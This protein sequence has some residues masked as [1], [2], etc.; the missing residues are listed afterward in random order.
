V[1]GAALNPDA[2]NGN[3]RFFPRPEAASMRRITKKPPSYRLHKPSNRAV[4]TLDGRD[5]YLGP[6]GSEESRAEYDRVVAEWLVHRCRAQGSPSSSSNPGMTVNELLVLYWRFAEEHYRRDGRP[7]RHLG[8]IRD[9]LRPVRALY[10]RTEA[11]EFGAAAFKAVR[12][13]MIDSGLARRTIAGRTGKVRQM[14]RWAVENEL[15]PPAVYQALVAVSGLKKGRGGVRETAP[16][17]PVPADR[18]EAVLPYLTDQVRGLV[19]L[20]LLA[21][22]RPGETVAMRADEIDCSGDVWVYRPTRHKTEGSDRARTILIGPRAQEVVRPFLEAAADDGY[23]FHPASAVE[24][25][26]ERRRASRRTPMTPS[27]QARTR[28]RA[29]RRAPGPFYS[30]SAYRTAIWRG[31][32]RAFP[33]PTLSA[34]DPGDLTEAQRSELRAWRKDHR[35]HPNQLRHAAA[36]SIRARFGL[37]AAQAVLGHARADVTQVYAERDIAK[38]VEVMREV[39]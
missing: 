17:G 8:N 14:F 27:Q 28:K 36:T 5:F 11:A 29:P 30:R 25:R 31:C 10:G 18:V 2:R 22:M 23:L 24:S 35:W 7:T 3:Y 26:N 16:I 9:A 12:K 20:Q 4:V 1:G 37:E 39:G 34:I 32:D 13:S 33:H 19:R 38:A 21:G 15:V 6:Y